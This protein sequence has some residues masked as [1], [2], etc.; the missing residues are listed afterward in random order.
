MTV[1]LESILKSFNTGEA[2]QTIKVPKTVWRV[3]IN[4]QFATTISG[5]TVWKR[6]SDAKNAI[7][8]HVESYCAMRDT[9]QKRTDT[10][11]L[12]DRLLNEGHIQF[13]ELPI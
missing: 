4:G 6:L 9:W 13:V 7:R 3:K 12:Y 10:D 8:N 5:K 2:G 11:S 1:T